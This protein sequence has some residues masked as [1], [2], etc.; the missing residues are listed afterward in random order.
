MDKFNIHVLRFFLLLNALPIEKKREIM[1]DPDCAASIQECFANGEVEISSSVVYYN[2][3][4][5]YYLY[6]YH[7]RLFTASMVSWE[8]TNAMSS[9][10]AGESWAEMG[11]PT[12]K[13]IAAGRRAELMGGRPILQLK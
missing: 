5:V 4:V 8:I 11:R 10:F 12:L 6:M 13:Q 9:V 1:S 3:S 7:N 2:S